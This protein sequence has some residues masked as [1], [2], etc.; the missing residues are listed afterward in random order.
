MPARRSR[1]DMND[2]ISS[3]TLELSSIS[4]VAAKACVRQDTQAV[5]LPPYSKFTGIFHT[6]STHK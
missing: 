3:D 6:V 1:A 4:I 5:F 2:F